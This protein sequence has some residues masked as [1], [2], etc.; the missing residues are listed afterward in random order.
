MRILWYTITVTYTV[1][2]EIISIYH[3]GKVFGHN[4]TLKYHF[5]AFWVF[6]RAKPRN[7]AT[8]TVEKNGHGDSVLCHYSTK[9]IIRININNL[10]HHQS[11]WLEF[12]FKT[13]LFGI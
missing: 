4:D 10:P 8:S 9:P 1:Y 6:F 5:L 2:D 12:H 3:T 7:P 13:S 11:I